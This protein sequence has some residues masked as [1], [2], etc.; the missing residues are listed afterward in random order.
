MT[1]RSDLSALDRKFRAKRTGQ[2]AVEYAASVEIYRRP[3][4]WAPRIAVAVLLILAAAVVKG[5]T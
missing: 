1:I 2:S 5:L 3:S 4:S